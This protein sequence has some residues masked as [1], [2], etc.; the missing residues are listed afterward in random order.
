MDEALGYRNC[1]QMMRVNVLHNTQVK[2]KYNKIHN[3]THWNTQS[4]VRRWAIEADAVNSSFVSRWHNMSYTVWKLKKRSIEGISY[5][6]YQFLGYKWP[7][8][9]LLCRKK[10][11]SQWVNIN[12]PSHTHT[13]RVIPLSDIFCSLRIAT[14]QPCMS[15]GGWIGYVHTGK[16]SPQAVISDSC[17]NNYP[18]FLRD[19]VS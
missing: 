3:L 11:V 10:L 6:L 7:W 15:V 2:L 8:N 1:Q 14:T 12:R 16:I 18:I 19:A 4:S 5:R 13:H 17:Q 9:D